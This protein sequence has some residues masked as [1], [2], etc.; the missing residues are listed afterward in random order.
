MEGYEKTS[1]LKEKL[2]E[3]Q[4]QIESTIESIEESKTYTIDIGHTKIQN[5]KATLIIDESDKEEFK[6]SIDND[7]GIVVYVTIRFNQSE[8]RSVGT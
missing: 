4:Q 1:V 3:I 6:D 8:N 2:F 5:N 7:E